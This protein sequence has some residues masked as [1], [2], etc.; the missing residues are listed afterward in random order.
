MKKNYCIW[1]GGEGTRAQGHISKWAVTDWKILALFTF[2]MEGW[3]TLLLA[4]PNKV[5]FSPGEFPIMLVMT[6]WKM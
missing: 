6:E 5:S 2:S 1:Q 4:F 3:Y